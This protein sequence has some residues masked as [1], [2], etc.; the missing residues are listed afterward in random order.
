MK[1]ARRRLSRSTAY[2]RATLAALGHSGCGVAAA[3]LYTWASPQRDPGD[4]ADW[5]GISP[6]GAGTDVA[7]HD[8]AA[9]TAFQAGITAARAPAT[10]SPC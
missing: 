2:V 6:E 5:Y 3:S 4:A 9:V 8:A 1:K 7:G 10:P